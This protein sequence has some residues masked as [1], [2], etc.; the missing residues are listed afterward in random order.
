MNRPEEP[1]EPAR[2]V[3]DDDVWE[4]LVRWRAARRG[5]VLASVIDTRGFTPRKA[6]ARM[7]VD[8]AGAIHGTI[9]GGAIEQEVVEAARRLLREG[10]CSSVVERHLTQE[11]GMCCGGAMT[12]HLERIA[13]KPPLLMFGAGHVAK[14]LAAIAAGCGFEVTVVDARAEWASP[15]RFPSAAILAR[16]PGAFARGVET[17]GDEFVVIATHDHAVDQEVV[18][19]L[20]PRPLRFLGMIGSVAKQR[21]FALRLAA[22][23]FSAEQ[24]ARLKTPLGFSIGAHSPEEIAVSVVAELIAVRHGATPAPAWTP[25]PRERGEAATPRLQPALERR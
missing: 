12:V 11:L 19:H 10:G 15:E 7:L 22:R 20:L 6:G 23:G 5:F 3:R 17:R 9:G 18:Q 13:L 4:A 14:P 2:L 25:R 1:A 16:D 21:K 24:I 8:E